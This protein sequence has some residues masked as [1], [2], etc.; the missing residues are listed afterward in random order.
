M[1]KLII[2]ADYGLDDAAA[3]VSIFNRAERF[4]TIDLV[5]IGGNV[6]AEISLRNCLTLLSFYP[7]LHGK[8]RVVSTCHIKQASEYLADIH[9]G[10][11]MGDFFVHP[12][13]PPKVNTVLF[14]EFLEGV[15]GDETLLSL[16]PTTLVRVLLEKTSVKKLIL[17]GGVVKSAPNFNGYEFNQALD[18]EAFAFC[19]KH[20]HTAITLDTCRTDKLD[21]RLFEISGE[22]IHSRIII[23]DQKLSIT[24]GEEGCFVWDDVAACYLLFPQRFEVKEEADPYGNVISNA[25]YISDK[26]YFED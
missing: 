15:T 2:F 22:D 4:D 10:D 20:P 19:L 17:M 24:R 11:G 8:I 26:L 7:Q 1:E 16:G 25:K 9:G 21:M 23:A 14:E 13:N 3:T 18:V 6:P 12:E 5:A